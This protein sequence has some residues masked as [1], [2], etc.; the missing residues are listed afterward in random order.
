MN[1]HWNLPVI[2]KLQ[3]YTFLEMEQSIPTEMELVY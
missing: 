1:R 2:F 3:N